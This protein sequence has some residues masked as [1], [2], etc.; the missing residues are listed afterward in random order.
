[1]G[2]KG[3]KRLLKV[4]KDF[5]STP[6]GWRAS[7]WWTF[8]PVEASTENL[9]R[10]QRKMSKERLWVGV[11]GGR[12]GRGRMEGGWSANVKVALTRARALE[13]ARLPAPNTLPLLKHLG[14]AAGAAPGEV[15]DPLRNLTEEEDEGRGRH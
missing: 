5:C 12:G 11:C 1:M 7:F 15:R 13:P 14:S 9:G 8:L 3:P 6:E 10:I 4:K 2:D